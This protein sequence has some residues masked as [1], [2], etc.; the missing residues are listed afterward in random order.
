MTS[1]GVQCAQRGGYSAECVLC[2]LYR[3]VL[4]P[5][6]QFD[7]HSYQIRSLHRNNKRTNC[8]HVEQNKFGLLEHIMCTT[9]L[10]LLH[11][12]CNLENLTGNSPL[13]TTTTT[14]CRRENALFYWSTFKLQPHFMITIN[15]NIS[16][17][18]ENKLTPFH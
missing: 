10:H 4:F 1:I 11:I 16:V 9:L 15:W 3:I 17:T 14:N 7:S 18:E 13:T 8:I 6:I 2:V 12:I 5:P